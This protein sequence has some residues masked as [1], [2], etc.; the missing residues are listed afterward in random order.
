[1]LSYVHYATALNSY[2]YIYSIRTPVCAAGVFITGIITT[3]IPLTI[4]RA[5]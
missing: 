5:Q 4:N 2:L 1:M 3:S